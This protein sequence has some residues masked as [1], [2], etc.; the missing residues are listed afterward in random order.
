[1]ATPQLTPL[2]IENYNDLKFD[3]RLRH[4]A[5]KLYVGHHEF[6]SHWRDA[7]YF[8]CGPEGEEVQFIYDF[9][10]NDA[11]IIWIKQ[12]PVDEFELVN[13]VSVGE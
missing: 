7:L 5:S 12:Y 1:M 3:L 11:G 10:I 2:I 8:T 4:K 9:F 13:C 6:K